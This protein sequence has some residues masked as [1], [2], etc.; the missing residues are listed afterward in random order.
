MSGTLNGTILAHPALAGHVLYVRTGLRWESFDIQNDGRVTDRQDP[1][2][3][4][5]PDWRGLT[6]F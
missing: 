2:T 5:D 4:G 3:L 1:P 6:L